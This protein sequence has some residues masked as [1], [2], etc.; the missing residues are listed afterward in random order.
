MVLEDSRHTGLSSK[1][2]STYI[3]YSMDHRIYAH[4]V[5]QGVTKYEPPFPEKFIPFTL[6]DRFTKQFL[7]FLTEHVKNELFLVSWEYSVYSVTI[8]IEIVR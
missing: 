8:K 4:T 5:M 2:T 6:L 3:P 1:Y 7:K